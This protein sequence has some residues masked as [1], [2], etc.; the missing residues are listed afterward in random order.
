MH[1]LKDIE[2]AWLNEGEGLDEA[3]GLV[4][5]QMAAIVHDEIEAAS[6]SGEHRLDGA[7]VALIRLDVL[8][9]IA[10]WPR[11]CGSGDV[12]ADNHCARKAIGE[13]ANRR[14]HT[15]VATQRSHR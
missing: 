11:W 3:R 5:R 4:R 2:T 1:V 14:T 12:Y 9:A 15:S 6:Q 13:P 8:D 10:V 7:S